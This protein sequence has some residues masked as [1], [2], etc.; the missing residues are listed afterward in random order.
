MT[1]DQSWFAQQVEEY[2]HARPHY[3]TLA[4]TLI[5]VL[6]AV[7]RQVA[8]ASIVQARAKTVPSFADKILRKAD[9]HRQPI[10]QLTDLCG[11]RVITHTRAECDAVAQFIRQHFD[12]DEANSEDTVSRLRAGEFGYRG[13]HLVVQFKPHAPS[14]GLLG[15]SISND[16]LPQ[17]DRPMKA[18]I[19]VRTIAQHVWADI[20][21]DRLYKSAF[22]VP[23]VW[24]REAARVAALLESADDTFGQLVERVDAYRNNYD[25]YRHREQMLEEL[26]RLTAV[27]RFDPENETL[28][29]QSARLATA[30]EDWPRVVEII[31]AFAGPRSATLSA[32]LGHAQCQLHALDRHGDAYAAARRHFDSALQSD[33]LH[34]EA[35][36]QLAESWADIDNERAVE[37]YERAFRASPEDP[38]TL[39]S[40]LIQK[41]AHDCDLSAVALVRPSIEE[42]I[43]RCAHQ[44]EV[45]VNLPW[46]WYW[47]ALL[48]LVL[49]RPYPALDDL[50]R[51]IEL[52]TAE[53]MIG[54]A[55]KTVEK[56]ACVRHEL[57]ALEWA[58]RLLLL[59]KAARFPSAADPCPLAALASDPLPPFRQPIVILAGGCDADVQS[60][61]HAYRDLLDRA[62]AGFTGTVISGGTTAG[63]AGLA[64]DLAASHGRSLQVVGYVPRTLPENAAEDDR[65]SLVVQTEGADFTPLEP[66]QNWIDLLAAGISPHSVTLIGINGG[67]LSRFEYSLARLLGGTVAIVRGSGREASRL[68]SEFENARPPRLLLLPSDGMTL[69]NLVQ[70][71][72]PSTLSS[73]QRE[74]AGRAIHEDYRQQQRERFAQQP[75]VDPAM[76]SWE[77]LPDSLKSSNLQQADHVQHKLAALGL[78]AVP[79][80]NAVPPFEFSPDQVEIL[81]EMEHG[82]W[83]VER[84][85]DGWTL[86]PRNV[87][88]KTSPYLVAWDE[89]PDNVKDY[90]RQAVKNIP[91]FLAQL[92]LEIRPLDD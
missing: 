7:A 44:A 36:L 23:D 73:D 88:K 15:E 68:E 18:E 72:M 86:G 4:D 64:G 21:H 5:R 12:V 92:G 69:R 62:F 66:L 14:Q 89:L 80:K 3:Q 74:A 65:Y 41:I 52:S 90:D 24:R 77:E 76:L 61:M 22:Q 40:F 47:R 55:L 57:P 54:T 30:L 37:L 49:Q 8:P 75:Q 83:N 43:D 25:A 56:L 63:I 28:A 34:L 70:Q 59:G 10:R 31:T 26:E 9:K 38:R 1:I 42:A 46:A 39:V 11:A 19:Q 50:C 35:L 45:G 87:E 27:L 81:A 82:R 84:L 20:G 58:R 29:K 16:V 53:Y 67:L 71:G 33:P 17:P 60:K 79:A 78:R 32:L 48:Q 2:A 91:A 6:S 85:Q 51:A 13:I